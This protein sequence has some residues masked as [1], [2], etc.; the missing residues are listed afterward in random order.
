MFVLFEPYRDLFLTEPPAQ[1]VVE[2]IGRDPASH[3]A[4]MMM[5]IAGWIESDASG[6]WGLT[7][8]GRHLRSYLGS[9]V[10]LCP[11]CGGHTLPQM[12]PLAHWS[13]QGTLWVCP[14]HPPPGGSL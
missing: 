5:I 9:H 11:V 7:A 10:Y 6:H 14:V 12:G 13:G 2:M 8:A 3:K 4:L 1:V